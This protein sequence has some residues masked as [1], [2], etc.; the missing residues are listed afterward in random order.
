[1]DATKTGRL[2]RSYRA[3]ARI[4]GVVVLGLAL[5]G[6]V[7]GPVGALSGP[8]ARPRHPNYV[9]LGDSY[10]AGPLIPGQTLEPRGCLRSTND[11]AHVLAPS[12][13]PATTL[14]DVS[15]SGATT[16]NM[17]SAQSVDSGTN[18]PQ[19]DAL[20]SDTTVVTLAIGGNDLGFGDIL[21]NCASVLPFGSRCK[22]QYDSGG[23]DQL[24]A[25]VQAIAPLV[26]KVLDGIHARAPHAKVYVVGYPAILPEHGGGCWPRMPFS[27]SDVRY[28]RQTE[29]NLNAM[30]QQTAEA[31][32]ASYIDTYAA[33]ADFNAC[34]SHDV[35][36][37]DPLLNLTD[38]A[39][40]HPNARGEAGMA[41]TL[42]AAI[43]R[44]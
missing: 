1:M 20:D 43:T 13:V 10:A 9:A 25:R 7:V 37:I 21:G 40:V 24:A 15:C 44:H 17:T 39:P 26:A 31:N 6:F 22:D 28:L 29:E 41:A 4:V 23:N 38:G 36:W 42:L 34:T 35:R 32:R 19:L 12:L 18:P 5:A 27:P 16:G 14:R 33:S 3:R 8:P 30:L 2:A 11:Y